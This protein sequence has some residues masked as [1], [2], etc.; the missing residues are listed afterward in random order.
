MVQ[1]LYLGLA[2]S[3]HGDRS[4]LRPDHK[5]SVW[6]WFR[7][8]ALGGIRFLGPQLDPICIRVRVHNCKIC[9]VPRGMH[10]L[11]GSGLMTHFSLR[12][13]WQLMLSHPTQSLFIGCFP[14]GATTLINGAL[15]SLPG[16]SKGLLGDPF[17]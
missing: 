10:S 8:S 11:N 7:S 1:S 15:V 6:R 12:Q 17:Q 2:R 5:F 4:N 9:D 3:H 13:V 16:S 14:M